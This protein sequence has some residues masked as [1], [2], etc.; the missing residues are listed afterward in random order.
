MS[1]LDDKP[2]S[3]PPPKLPF[4][5]TPLWWLLPVRSHVL[6]HVAHLWCLYF[7]EPSFHSHAKFKKMAPI[8]YITTTSAVICY[9]ITTTN[10]FDVTQIGGRIEKL[11]LWVILCFDWDTFIFMWGLR[12]WVHYV[13][14]IISHS[15]P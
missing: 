2:P 3:L 5:A 4:V 7:F 10:S 8:Y 14:T 15:L 1:S 13:T 9:N 12:R 6:W 11:D